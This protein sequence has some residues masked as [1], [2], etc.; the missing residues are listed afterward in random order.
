M[1]ILLSTA[2]IFR[3]Y[4]GSNIF[5]LELAK[6]FLEQKHSV[7][8]YSNLALPPMYD[9]V[10]KLPYQEN[11]HIITDPYED[12]NPQFDLIFIHESGLPDSV[13]DALT[14]GLNSQ[15]IYLHLSSFVH[16]EK[17]IFYG[18]ENEIA[19]VVACVS[20]EAANE[21]VKFGI[22]REKIKV[23]GNFIESDFAK[24]PKKIFREIPKKLLVVS[25]HIPEE[26]K[27]AVEKLKKCRT[28]VREIGAGYEEKLV[29]AKDI[30]DADVVLTIG[31]TVQYALSSG[32]PVFMY[33]HFG[34]S[35]YLVKKNI[36]LAEKRNFSGRGFSRKTTEEIVSEIFE[37]YD[38][39]LRFS[40]KN[41]KKFAKKF[42]IKFRLKEAGIILLKTP[43][44]KRISEFDAEIWKN[45]CEIYRGSSRTLE[46]YKDNFIKKN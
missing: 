24:N 29:D 23:L 1:R 13:I 14:K 35:G 5:L 18:I 2:N 33:D 40:R 44:M 37:N 11:L 27:T 12:V 22:K 21:M 45:F 28:E 7:V 41:Q 32:V 3:K 42:A 46:Y 17:P 36:E 4:E 34:G 30:V 38:S 26:M 15:I 9:E 39:A 19:D 31:K 25:N 8:L 43:T 10:M 16:I 6:Y 20:D